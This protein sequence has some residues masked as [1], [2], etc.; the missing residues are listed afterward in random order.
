MC[1]PIHQRL[2]TLPPRGATALGSAGTDRQ[3]VERC[4]R[5]R[6]L[7]ASSAVAAPLALR[8]LEKT[9]GARSSAG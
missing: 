6:A 3:A 4:L 2:R 9:L 5:D 7:P 8:Y 1:A